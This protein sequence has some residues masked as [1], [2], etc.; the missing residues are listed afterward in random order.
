[1]LV[2]GGETNTVELKLAA[3]RAVD[4]AER[5]CGMA[6][7]RGGMVIIGVEDATHK[8]VGVPDE[9]IGETMD[10][11]L[12]AARQVI[13]PALVLDPPEPEIYVVAGKKLLVVTIVPTDGPVYQA[14]GIFWIRQ[15]T[16]TRALSLAELSEMIYDRGLRDWELE[17]AYNTTMED[18][19]MEK[20][21]S[22]VARRS[23]SGRQSGRFKNREQV[24]IGMRCAV[25]VK[26]GTLVPTNAG[27]LF[28]GHAPQDHIPQS[29]VVCVLFR[30]TVGA[31]RYADRKIVTGTLQDLIDTT[32]AFLDRYIAVGARVEGWKR[33]DIPEYSIEVLREAVINAVVHRD[34]SRRGERVRVFYYPDRVEVHSP[35]LL[36]PGITVEQ[37]E[38]GEVQ[39]KLRNPVLAGLLSTLPGYMEQIGSGV[40][41][42]LDETKRMDLPAPQFRERSEFIVT[43]QKAPA[44]RARQARVQYKG[45]TLWQEEEVSLPESVV[46]NRRAEQIE[47]RLIQALEYVQEQGFITNGIYRQLTGVTERTAHRDLERLVERGRLKGTGQRA[48]RR[49]VLT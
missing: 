13:K 23:A 44:L 26:D 21:T 7:A 14:G 9:R 30:E 29:E 15:G 33:I 40:R 25:A 48:A 45:E 46:Q 39:S 41:F 17:P 36:L 18:I 4:L 31:S 38:R 35:G 6:N 42:M 20:V 2:K 1:M 47:K 3:P 11:I 49:Y 5:L 34:Y 10:V 16:Q 28:F 12:R 19:D 27:L 8:I 43:F 32:E 24:L 37:M 22:F